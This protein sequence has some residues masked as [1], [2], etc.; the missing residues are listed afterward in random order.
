MIEVIKGNI[1]KEVHLINNRKIGM[2]FTVLNSFL[3]FFALYMLFNNIVQANDNA[4]STFIIS[5][6]FWYFSLSVITDPGWVIVNESSRG[7]IEQWWLSPYP[8]W[9]I[10]LSKIIAG[11]LVN[12]LR[13]IMLLILIMITTRP[14]I[15]FNLQTIIILFIALVGMY[16]VG[17]ILAGFSIMYKRIQDIIPILQYI[18]LATISLPAINHVSFTLIPIY[19][20]SILLKKSI[21]GK[22]IAFF[23][24]GLFTASS[25]LVFILGVLFFICCEKNVRKKGNLS[26]V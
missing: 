22:N 15:L 6:V 9:G 13:T 2:L 3:L 20:S 11:N 24:Y 16:G 17:F 4:R 26:K 18:L 7:T 19:S 25:V 12:S 1:I 21:I 10:L 8:F 5:Y 14:D 23:E